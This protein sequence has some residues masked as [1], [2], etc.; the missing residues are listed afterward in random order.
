MTQNIPNLADIEES[1]A[2][3]AAIFPDFKPSKTGLE[4]WFK[5]V[6]DASSPRLDIIRVSLFAGARAQQCV[7]SLKK[8]MND[9]IIKN[10][11]LALLCE[12]LDTDLRV[13]ELDVEEFKAHPTEET[14][15]LALTYGMMSVEEDL[16]LV[17]TGS[18]S[19]PLYD[20]VPT[21]LSESEHD[22]INAIIGT[23]FSCFAARKPVALIDENALYA[24][25][26]LHSYS[27]KLIQTC[28]YAGEL[29]ERTKPLLQEMALLS[30]TAD[31]EVFTGEVIT[32]VLSNLKDIKKV[33]RA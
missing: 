12:E 3:I 26:V 1:F 9:I 25:K 32:T 5:D 2:Q 11:P 16:N 6:Q 13:Y 30:I 28:F 23:I 18:L 31:K 24:A 10:H 21:T 7:T 8:E 19:T 20:E 27:P 4:Q 29:N 17:V 33:A 15:T 22:D 14:I